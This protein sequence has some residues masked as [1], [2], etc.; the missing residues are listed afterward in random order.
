MEKFEAFTA[1]GVLITDGL[2][3]WTNDLKPGAV[4]LASAWKESNGVVWF[5]IR[6]DDGEKG[7]ADGERM[8]TV[9]PFTRKPA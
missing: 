9:H 2:R 7:M 4:I 1:D 8:A 5:H 3:V 6:M